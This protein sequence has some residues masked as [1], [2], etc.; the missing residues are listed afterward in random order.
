MICLGGSE[1]ERAGLAGDKGVANA[2]LSRNSWKSWL[3][4]HIRVSNA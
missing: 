1:M 4:G 2:L 3:C